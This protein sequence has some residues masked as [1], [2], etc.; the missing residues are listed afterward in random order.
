VI[1]DLTWGVG[2]ALAT[3]STPQGP[4]V[5]GLADRV[6]GLG[7]ESAGGVHIEGNFD[8]R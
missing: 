6:G 2:G 7:R 8:F 4:W 5:A 1:Q 3:L